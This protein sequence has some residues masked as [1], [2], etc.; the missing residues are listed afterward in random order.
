[1]DWT[2]Q[3]DGYC[4]RVGPGLW[5]EPV[6]AVTNLAFLFVAVLAWRAAR[7][8]GGWTLSAMLGVIGVASGL[9]HTAA[10]V[11]TGA[12]DSLSIAVFAFTYLWLATGDF[13]GLHGK[14]RAGVFA[15]F[16]LLLVAAVRYA[17]IT[18]PVLGENAAYLGI[19][20]L[21]LGW[22]LG[23]RGMGLAAGR[24]LLIAAVI[25]GLS[26]LLRA[27]DGRL[28]GSLSIGTH[29]LWHLLNAAALWWMIEVR[30]RHLGGAARA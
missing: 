2:A 6:N 1:M 26:I 15:G 23:L 17:V 24:G 19:W 28:C 5:A 29:W 14:L 10:T 22:G 21:I 4:E 27:L 13:L 8:P 9:F 25:L 7:E 12:L 30:R 11:A 3:V 18:A 16:V 20:A